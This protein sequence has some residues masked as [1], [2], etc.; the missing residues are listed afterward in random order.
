[1]DLDFETTM[2]KADMLRI[3]DAKIADLKKVIAKAEG[4]YVK[5][6]AEHTKHVAAVLLQ[7]SKDVAS[8]KVK[9]ERGSWCPL[10]RR[11]EDDIG[12]VPS[13]C[14]EL[15]NKLAGYEAV[16][17][18]LQY[19]RGDPMRVQTS[20]VVKWLSGKTVTKRMR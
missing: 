7:A 11:V 19:H 16:R 8:G 5:A 10:R 15:E 2:A 9:P 20:Q 3:V 12:E 18:Q 4:P 1:M 6:M 13:F 14:W 17:T